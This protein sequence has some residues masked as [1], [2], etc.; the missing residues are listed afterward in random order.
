[1][2]ILF[3]PE[4]ES[5]TQQTSLRMRTVWCS[6]RLPEGKQR[7]MLQWQAEG[8]NSWLQIRMLFQIGPCRPCID[9]HQFLHWFG[10]FQ[11]LITR[12]S[13]HNYSHPHL[14]TTSVLSQVSTA[15]W[16]KSRLEMQVLILW[17]CWIFGLINEPAS[18]NERSGEALAA[19]RAQ[20]KMLPRE[21]WRVFCC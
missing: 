20:P 3:L 7:P 21:K 8:Q 10:S 12:I 1:M 14:V 5:W 6:G 9:L 17:I 15:T 13:I 16:R 18:I 2:L 4:I 11:K 19:K